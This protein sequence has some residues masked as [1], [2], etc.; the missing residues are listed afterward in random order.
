MELPEKEEEE[1]EEERKGEFQEV[2]TAPKKAA[3]G[4]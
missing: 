4:A 2:T 1:E 3:E